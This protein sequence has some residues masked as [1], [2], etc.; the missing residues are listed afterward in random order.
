MLWLISEVSQY[1]NL[2]KKI[3]QKMKN[4]RFHIFYV[5]QNVDDFQKKSWKDALK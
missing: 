4:E 3:I 2:M 5:V 1:D